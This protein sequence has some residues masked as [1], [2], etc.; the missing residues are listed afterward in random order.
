MWN[1][2]MVIL[3]ENRRILDRRY[4]TWEFFL[5]IILLRICP[6]YFSEYLPYPGT[7]SAWDFCQ[8]IGQKTEVIRGQKF[9]TNPNQQFFATRKS[10]EYLPDQEI[11]IWS[12]S[13]SGYWPIIIESTLFER[14]RTP[15]RTWTYSLPFGSVVHIA[16]RHL[17]MSVDF[18]QKRLR[19]QL[20]MSS[21]AYPIA[22][23]FG[24]VNVYPI[25]VGINQIE[26][27]QCPSISIDQCRP[28]QWID[29][30]RLVFRCGLPLGI[31]R[32]NCWENRWY[33]PISRPGITSD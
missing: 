15:V 24:V 13:R 27:N 7:F 9:W 25:A 16:T 1:I 20:L 33:W 21:T 11:L 29:V 12:Y 5:M 19:L 28:T 30:H 17:S 22:T 10:P 6:V 32:E 2:P 23:T 8:N 4:Q 31:P 26:V 18:C 14:E 3:S